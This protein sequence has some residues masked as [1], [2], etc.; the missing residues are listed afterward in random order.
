[1]FQPVVEPASFMQAG[2][3]GALGSIW[4]NPLFTSLI[5][6][7]LS[8]GTHSTAKNVMQMAKGPPATA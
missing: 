3:L 7:L 4:S 2:F 5:Y 1:M 8:T 6:T